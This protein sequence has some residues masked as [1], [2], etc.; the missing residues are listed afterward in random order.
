MV[1]LS[2]YEWVRRI[3]ICLH[4][5]QGCLRKLAFLI[6]AWRGSPQVTWLPTRGHI[7]FLIAL[8]ALLQSGPH[9]ALT[10][11]DRSVSGVPLVSNS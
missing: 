10:K 6:T 9:I 2:G 4:K 3:S 11:H 1:K 7:R 5:Q 8:K